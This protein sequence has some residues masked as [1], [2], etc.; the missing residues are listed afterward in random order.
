MHHVTHAHQVVV[1]TISLQHAVEHV[2]KYSAGQTAYTVR[3]HVNMLACHSMNSAVHIC[4][5]AATSCGQL[6]PGTGFS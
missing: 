6:I 5:A 1:S 3:Q 2:G 4:R